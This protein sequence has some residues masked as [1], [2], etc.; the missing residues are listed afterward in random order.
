M[1]ITT[2][3]KCTFKIEF[4]PHNINQESNNTLWGRLYYED[5][6][7]STIKNA[8]EQYIWSRLLND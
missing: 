5:S 2:E 1:F 3:N 6:N 7:L 8:Y 4:L